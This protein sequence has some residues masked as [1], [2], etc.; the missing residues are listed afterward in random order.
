MREI[1]FSSIL[2]WITS[3]TAELP[4]S[5]EGSFYNVRHKIT[6]VWRYLKAEMTDFS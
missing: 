2:T 6:H 1:I 4:F 3:Y 5:P